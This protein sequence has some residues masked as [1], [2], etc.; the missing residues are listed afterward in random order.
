MYGAAPGSVTTDGPLLVRCGVLKEALAAIDQD[1]QKS[2]EVLERI[3][4]EHLI[5]GKPVE[6]FVIIT[7]AL[8]HK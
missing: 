8:P 6:E 4:Q 5:R 2:P 3:I 1:S 7:H